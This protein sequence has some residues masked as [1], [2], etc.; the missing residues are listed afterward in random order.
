MKRIA[1]TAFVVTNLVTVFVASNLA[2]TYLGSSLSFLEH[3]NDVLSLLA[4]TSLALGIWALLIA[5][6]RLRSLLVALAV[7]AIGQLWWIEQTA[8]LAIWSINGFAP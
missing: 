3:R 6:H 4:L 2:I 1:W 5:K 8:T 7:L